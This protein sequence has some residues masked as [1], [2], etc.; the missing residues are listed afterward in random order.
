MI[1]LLV[2]DLDGVLVDAKDIH[3]EAFN[4]ALDKVFHYK[5]P[6]EE[7]YSVYDGLPTKQKLEV[8][9]QRQGLA[10]EKHMEV[11]T[12]KQRLTSTV[13]RSRI[14][15]DKRLKDVLRRFRERGL[16]IYVASNSIRETVKMFLYKTELI[17]Y[18]DHYLSNEDVEQPKPAPEVYLRCMIEARVKPEE[19]LIIEDSPKGLT[20]ARHSGAHV[21]RV[22][23]PE[24]VRFDDIM[25][26]IDEINQEDKMSKFEWKELNILIPMAGAG[27][28]FE[29]AG[30]TFPKPL[31]EVNGKPMIQVVVENLNI[32][33]N[34]IFIVREEHYSKYNLKYLLNL[35]T[36]KCKIVVID[37]MTE[38]AA[39][40]TLLAEKHINNDKP[41][42]I[43][44]SDQF[45]EWDSA[46]F[47]YKMLESDMDG[48]I[49]TFNA[50]HPKW[51][52][53][54]I[55]NGFVAEVA[56]KKPISNIATCGVYYY[57]KGSDYVK[58]AGQMIEK[59]IRT[60]GEFYVCPVYNEFIEA[61]KK[62]KHYPVEKM[63]GLGTPED[64]DAFLREK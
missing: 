50:T 33:A 4:E 64:L 21:M 2:F 48:C 35:I 52:Y 56:E 6:K 61:G 42:L 34:Y 60:N 17:E 18:I 32:D 30:F 14:C 22:A 49:L 51:S 39:C 20:A 55:E 23:N 59:D 37:Q 15:G 27:K 46:D 1:K 57:R 29:Q 47:S 54:K 3:F 25:N 62:I 26:R 9:T 53:V 11:W 5:I 38:G 36:P 31:I 63:T 12:E 7:H 13:I 58:Y 43:A 10:T 24:A 16:K 41:L 40:T 44:N 8:L 45:I 28:R 19:V